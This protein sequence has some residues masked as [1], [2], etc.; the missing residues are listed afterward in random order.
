MSHP[1]KLTP[2]TSKEET[3][4]HRPWSQQVSKILRKSRTMAKSSLFTSDRRTINQL[5]ARKQRTTIRREDTSCREGAHQF[6]GFG[7]FVRNYVYSKR[8]GKHDKMNCN[9][10]FEELQ[11]YGGP[12]LSHQN[13]MLTSNSS[14]SHHIQITHS[15]FKSLTAN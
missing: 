1:Q 3:W 2:E 14:H 15:K 10:H 13:K 11:N 5:C 8:W 7:D 12:Q 4:S 9:E 6:S